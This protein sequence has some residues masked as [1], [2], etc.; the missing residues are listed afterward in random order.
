MLSTAVGWELYEMTHSALALGLVGLMKFLPVFVL[1]LPVGHFIDRWNSKWL[2]IINQCVMI[3]ACIGLTLVSKTQG[4][5][6]LFYGCLALMGI[7][8]TVVEPARATFY[9]QILPTTSLHNAVTWNHVARQIATVGGPIA[10]GLAIAISG[11]ARTAYLG[12]AALS[13]LFIILVGSVPFT[14][15]K[16]S[17]EPLTLASL[18]GGIRFIGRTKIILS[19]ITVDLF[20]VLFGGVTALL[21]IFAKDILHIGPTGL[22]FLRAAPAIGALLM[23]GL[24]AYRRPLEKAGVTLLWSVA[25]F[26]IATILFGISTNPWLSFLLLLL[27]GSFDAVSVIIRHTLLQTRT[28]ASLL[29]RVYAVNNVFG[30]SS[31]ELGEVES[32]MVA[33][34]IGPILA[35]LTGGVGSILVVLFAMWKW[36]EIVR[37]KRLQEP[38]VETV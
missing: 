16:R 11:T 32:G 17:T 7:A 22:G 24:I 4:P 37:L 34:A 25:G 29:G 31:N 38:E 33:A 21:P 19:T 27:T 35:T 3:A 1:S 23:S 14:T 9:P 26:G 12:Y 6:V 8:L 13:V 15:R 2:L 20:A 30:I 10:G 28:P 5:L 36:P 18:L